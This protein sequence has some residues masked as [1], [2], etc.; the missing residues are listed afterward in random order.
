MTHP[1]A[2]DADIAELAGRLFTMARTGDTAALASYLD[3]G[4][5]ADLNNESG[6]TLVMLA[7]Y[8]GHAET[9]RV[10]VERGADV[11]RPN[12]KGQTPLAGAVFKGEDDVVQ[13]LVEGGA[14][15]HGGHPSAI[16][17]A[18]MFGREDYLGILGK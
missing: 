18:R 9:V 17:A 2:D 16:D 3:A 10:L 11:N 13:A 5:P 8:H 7:S 6:D 15:P 12:D 14:D 4:V 1:D